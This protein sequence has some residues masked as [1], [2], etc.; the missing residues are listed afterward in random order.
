MPYTITQRSVKDLISDKCID[1]PKHQRPY[2][3]K[4]KTAKMFID[5]IMQGLPTHALILY[6]EVKDSKLKKWIEDGQQ[7]FMTVKQFIEGKKLD[8]KVFDVKYDGKTFEELPEAFK[9]QIMTYQFTICILEQVSK[10]SRIA[11]FQRLQDG[12]PLTN[13]QRFNAAS[14]TSL[15]K[16]AR[17][18]LDDPRTEEVW[19]K[20]KENDSFSKL[21]NAIAIAAG[22]NLDSDDH[23]TTSYEILAG[24]EDE[25]Q[26]SKDI[27]EEVVKDRL[28]KLFYI[29]Q[30]A[31]QECAV[32]A[33]KKKSE[34][35]VGKYT[36]YILYSIR[37]TDCNWE[38]ISKL[39]INYIVQCRKDMNKYGIL[40]Y[41]KPSSRNWTRERWSKGLTN[42][43]N[44]ERV[45]LE[46]QRSETSN[47]SEEE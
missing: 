25:Y 44:P 22:L 40:A 17:R 5:T 11:L 45:P 23:I 37:Q 1:I 27:K 41:E 39:W 7:R 14:D 16:L 10:E 15:V 34:F 13:G 36:G 21:T 8:G 35:N 31:Q 43:K 4:T 9:T 28:D 30:K 42:V 24:D 38:D 19:G 2:I 6:Q 12:K 47:D 18:I 20:Q 32:N 46:Y 3:W 29:Y 26:L 33:Q